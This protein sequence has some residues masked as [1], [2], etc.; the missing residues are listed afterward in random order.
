MVI[1][2]EILEAAI[3]VEN[4]FK[5]QNQSGR[6]LMGICDRAYAN[7]VKCPNCGNNRQV[8]INQITK[9]LTCHRVGCNNLE[10]DTDDC[11][12]AYNKALDVASE[13]AREVLQD[14]AEYQT[15][16]C[17]MENSKIKS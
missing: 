5:T 17:G 14:S 1:P 2:S 11:K 3:K 12:A 10:L 15:L 6:I 13:L 7:R 4:F 9:K 16:A 8:W